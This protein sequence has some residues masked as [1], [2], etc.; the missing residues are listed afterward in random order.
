[1]SLSNGKAYSFYVRQ[2]TSTF[3]FQPLTERFFLAANVLP[4]C[5]DFDLPI[6][7]LL[8]HPTYQAYQNHMALL[9][10]YANVYVKFLPPLWNAPTPAGDG[11]NKDKREWKRRLKMYRASASFQ[12]LTLKIPDFA[13]DVYS[14]PRSRGIRV[15]THHLRLITLSRLQVLVECQ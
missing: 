4:P 15:P 5:H 10:L 9:S 3:S 1:M 8:T 12:S 11:D 14:W 13:P 6:V 7:K 2:H